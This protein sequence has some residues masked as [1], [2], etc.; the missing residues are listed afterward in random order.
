MAPCTSLCNV[1]INDCIH[2]I[3]IMIRGK[4]FTISEY[5]PDI[6]TNSISFNYITTF[7]DGTTHSFSDVLTFPTELTSALLERK[8]VKRALESVHIILGLSYFKMFIP[9]KISLPYSLLSLIH[10]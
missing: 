8:D 10:I 1:W 3:R 2:E 5:I 9:P 4:E 7:D 6:Q